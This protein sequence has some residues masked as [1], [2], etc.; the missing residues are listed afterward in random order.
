MLT[1]L[2][3]GANGINAQS[4]VLNAISSNIA[5]A[6]TPGYGQ[7]TAITGSLPSSLVRPG[8]VTLGGQLLGPQLNLAQGVELVSNAPEF[9][10]A[11]VPSGTPSNMA[12]DGNGFFSVSLPNGQLA[13]TRNGNFMLDGNGEL[14]LPSGAR[15]YPPVNIPLGASYTIESNGTVM[16]QNGGGAPKKMAQ[17]KVAMIP[18]PQ[19]MLSAGN[20]LY[21]LSAASGPATMVTPGT[22]N[23]GSLMSSSLNQS[24][25]NLAAN[26]VNLVQAETLYNLSAKVVT[27]G[28]LV[29]Q[30][31]TNLQV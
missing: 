24:S 9:G 19:G 28:Q 29:T 14:V 6:N 30:A 31:T 12:I 13:Y 25:T 4:E 10:N 27:V 22:H 23:A 26:L 21:S 16:V 5:N 8:N 17:V 2:G 7:Q 11:I 18:N 1:V 20:S 3:V 15:L